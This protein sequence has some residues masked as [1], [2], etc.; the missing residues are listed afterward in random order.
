M[1]KPFATA[2]LAL[3]ALQ[4]VSGWKALRYTPEEEEGGERQLQAYSQLYADYPDSVAACLIVKDSN[5]RDDQPLILG[6]CD[7]TNQAWS[8]DDDGLY[9]TKLD[10]DYCMQAGRGGEIKD[11]V[12]MRIF[13][14]DKD[15]KRQQFKGP[16]SIG[17]IKLKDQDYDDFCV[18]F[19]GVTPNVNV[20]P[21]IVKTCDHAVAG[22]SQD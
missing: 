3:T 7:L 8:L 15:E 14:C 4:G 9:H 12:K 22:W 13:K 16:E 10:S 19:R 18:E 11:G 2:L 6:D 17:R 5:A 21:I 20:D 1:R